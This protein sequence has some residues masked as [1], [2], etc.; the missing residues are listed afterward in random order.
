MRTA[1][2]LVILIALYFSFYFSGG[3]LYTASQEFFSWIHAQQGKNAYLG[4]IIILLSIA[5]YLYV[6]DRSDKRKSERLINELIKHI[7]NTGAYASTTEN[8]G[9]GEVHLNAS[10]TFQDS[11]FILRIKQN[12]SSGNAIIL[13]DT[14]FLSWRELVAYIEAETEFTVAD[15]LPTGDSEHQVPHKDAHAK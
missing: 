8:T 7:K 4:G 6:L 3:L 10:I 5:L 13:V 15:F 1:I 2:A 9:F 12:S 14:K 11:G